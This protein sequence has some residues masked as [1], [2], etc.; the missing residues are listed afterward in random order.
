MAL[1]GIDVSEHQGSIDWSKVNA[2]GIQFAMIRAGYGKNNVDKYF[3]QNAKNALASGIPIG[4]YWFSY[5][6]NEEMAKNEATYAVNLAKQYNVTWPICYDLEYDTV[7]Y[8]A[9]NGVT[10]NKSLATKMAKAFC[11]QV[12]A[13]GYTPMNYTNLDYYNNYFDSSQLPYD[14]WYAQYSSKASISG[15]AIWQYS[16][17]GNVS[18]ISGKCDVNYAYKNYGEKKVEEEKL[19]QFPGNRSYKENRIN[20]RVHQQTVGWLDHVEDG[21]TAGITGHKK[22]LEAIK[23]DCKMSGVKIKAKAHIQSKG[24]V[25]Y[26]YITSDTVIGTTGQGLRLE[27][28]ELEAEGLPTGMNLYIRYHIEK[29][30]WSSWTTGAMAGTAGLA[31]QLEA[32]Q[33]KIQ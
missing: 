2:A 7:S 8:A 24:T 14:L 10:I 4:I 33:I 32:V 26:G 22:R 5:A 29:D 12:K 20:Y 15:M 18:G 11:K 17:F 1:K 31:K 23:I 28:L 6:L 30:G 27:G 21:Q 3:H 16:S 9:K 19:T 13:L 25:D